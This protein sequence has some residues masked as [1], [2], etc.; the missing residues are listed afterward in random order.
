ME[1]GLSRQTYTNQSDDWIIFYYMSCF[2]VCRKFTR[3]KIWLFYVANTTEIIWK[4]N[5]GMKSGKRRCVGFR[6]MVCVFYPRRV[7]QEGSELKLSVRFVIIFQSWSYK[8]FAYVNILKNIDYQKKKQIFRNNPFT[9]RGER[10][11]L[12]WKICVPSGPTKK[13]YR[14]IKNQRLFT[15]Q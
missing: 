11:C 2:F 12:N 6:V 14:T 9:N 15:W 7:F 1:K 8:I 3:N 5:E 4:E 10:N 13:L